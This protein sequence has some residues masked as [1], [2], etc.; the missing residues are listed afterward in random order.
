MGWCLHGVGVARIWNGWMGSI[1][2]SGREEE[3]VLG[4]SASWPFQVCLPLSE[5]SHLQILMRLLHE[6]FLLA[7][8]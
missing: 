6:P 7:R 5:S 4:S 2:F 3:G 1:E 8:W